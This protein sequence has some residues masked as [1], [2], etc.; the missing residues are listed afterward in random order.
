MLLT[1]ASR[2]MKTFEHEWILEAFGGAE[3]EAEADLEQI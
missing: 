2:E 1:I 3:E